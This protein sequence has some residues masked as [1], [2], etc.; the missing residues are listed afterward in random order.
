[1]VLLLIAKEDYFT[2]CMGFAFR[3]EKRSTQQETEATLGGSAATL[4]HWVSLLETP[5]P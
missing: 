3:E 5:D 4:C 2:S 1:M